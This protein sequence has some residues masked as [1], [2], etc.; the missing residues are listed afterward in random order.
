MARAQPVS[1]PSLSSSFRFVSPSSCRTVN[2]AGTQLSGRLFG[3]TSFW[4][5]RAAQAAGPSTPFEELQR[6][7]DATDHWPSG[8]SRQ[9]LLR[10]GDKL[11]ADAPDFDPAKLSGAAAERQF[12]YNNDF[13]AY[14]PL[15][16]GSDSSD[17][18]C[19][20]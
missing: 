6:V 14:L 5:P 10:W 1:T 18:A 16:Q 2:P 17:H 12:G 20:W 19:W 3:I 15:P 13:T 8:Y 11:F 4:T 7:T 9:V